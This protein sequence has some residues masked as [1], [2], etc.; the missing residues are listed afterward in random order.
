[1]KVIIISPTYNE[2]ENLPRLISILDKEIKLITNHQVEILF[3]DDNS[4]DG[5]AQLIEEYQQKYTWI[6]LLKRA[7]KQGL[8]KAYADGIKYAV[9]SLNAEAFIEFDADMQH[10]PEDIKRLIAELDNGFDYVIASRYVKGGSI[11]KQWGVD[12][13]LLSVIGNLV[14]RV[15]LLLPT[16]HDVTTGFKL[17][18]VSTVYSYLNLDNLISNQFAYK[19]QFLFE[20]VN[21]G[22]KVKEIPI[23]FHPRQQG[24]SKLI[25]NEMLETLRVIFRLQ[26]HNSKIREFI[27]F[28]IV[29]FT[30]FII[31]ST[32]LE[33]FSN[34]AITS[35]L[36]SASA[37]LHGIWGLQIMEQKASW[38]AAMAAEVAIVS[39][40][41]LNNL[42]TFRHNQITNPFK[43][44]GKFIQFNLTSF[45]AV[46]IQFSVIGLAV[47]MFGDRT[48]VRQLALIF[49]IGFLILPYN[50]LMYTKVIWRKK[51][52]I[53]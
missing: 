52:S 27:K 53:T 45:G 42:W 41:S 31:N 2:R 15:L 39:N 51:K 38:A 30:G 6:N 36:A 10:D 21:A 32:S 40:F 50:Y 34:M 8:G 16:I 25:K 24:E 22:V 46:L 11:P 7:H 4:P 47:S 35:N 49:A 37:P 9:N 20:T 29:G 3:V 5:T 13:K 33:I 19:I 48:F 26:Q 12:R 17:T 43:L 18:R 44:I 1:M 14:A 28:G 23:H